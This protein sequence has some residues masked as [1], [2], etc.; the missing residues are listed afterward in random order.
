V[1]SPNDGPIRGPDPREL[2]DRGLDLFARGQIDRSVATLREAFFGNLFIAPILLGV[3]VDPQGLWS[4]GPSGSY[5]AAQ[6]HARGRRR[7]WQET[8]GALRY[9]RCLWDDPLVRCEIRSYTNFCKSFSRS[10]REASKVAAELLAERAKFTNEK[11][12]RST[13]QEILDR[14]RDIRLDAPAAAPAI[15]EVGFAVPDPAATAECIGRVLGVAAAEHA[16]T[17]DRSVAFGDLTI[18]LTTGGEAPARLVLTCGV[19]DFDYYLRRVEDEGLRP[20]ASLTE[21]PR[22]RFILIEAPGG[23][24]LR[25][26][27]RGEDR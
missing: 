3:P 4:P 14:I 17:G 9:L 2:F 27:D 10:P 18:R 15:A 20:V 5:E 24:L 13:A 25:I 1:T 19:K 22:N 26:V 16:A 8:P 6:E 21:A 23:V 12:I 7:A 11:R